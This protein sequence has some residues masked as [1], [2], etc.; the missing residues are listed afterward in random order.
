MF[1]IN[2]SKKSGT[3]DQIETENQ[4][5]GKELVLNDAKLSH[6]IM[7]RHRENGKWKPNIEQ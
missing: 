1:R 5:A 6:L 3:N 4:T 2:F 7:N